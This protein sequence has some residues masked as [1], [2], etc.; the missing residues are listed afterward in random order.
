[1]GD[2]YPAAA[3]HA[4]P[5]GARSPVT[6]GI[7]GKVAEGITLVVLTLLV[8]R[9]LGAAD[10]GTFSV[11]LAI[12][13]IVTSAMAIGGSTLLGRYVP[14]ADPGDRVALA[15][16]IVERL[17]PTRLLQALGVL[18]ACVLVAVLA[19]GWIGAVA[20][21]L[22]GVAVALEIGAALA[23]QAALGLG[24][25]TLWS[26]RYPLQNTVLCIASLGLYALA[27]VD[28]AI[29][30]I[31]LAS[32]T[33]LLLGSLVATRELRGA[34][35]DAAI[36]E[37]A[38]RFGLLHGAG[39]LLTQVSYRGVPIAAALLGATEAEVG[40]AALASGIAIAVVYAVWQAFVVD[41][42]HVSSLAREQPEAAELRIRRLASTAT[43]VLVPSALAGAAL[44][45]WL[46][47]TLLG[48]GFADAV[49]A[50]AP[51]LA[52]LP[53]AA[54]AALVTQGSALRLRADVRLTS[55]AAGAAMFVVASIV[56]IPLWDAAGA[57]AALLASVSALVAA[58]A[59]QL[60]G[61]HGGRLLALSYGGA[62]LTLVVGL[63]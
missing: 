57:T 51:A 38:M 6:I 23:Y 37:G 30:G 35:R 49:P 41:L 52:V 18:A 15:R 14:A 31:V 27:G 22:V 8:P 2:P 26:F 50:F 20:I 11:A 19:P 9:A 16:S 1:M 45:P 17:A 13:T 25:T 54:A 12:V 44:A 46:V 3:A 63:T 28:G 43:L 5:T 48:D 21:V 59:V 42:P 7:A 39:G 47:P 4:V 33:A 53:L 56:A 24:H 62:A 55:S 40:Y 60:R 36:P 29:A 61:I 10:F 58:G 34:P 32:T